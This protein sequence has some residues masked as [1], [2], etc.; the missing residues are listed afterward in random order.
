MLELAE[1]ENNVTYASVIESGLGS[2]LCIGCEVFGRWSGQCVEL[3][4]ELACERT[5]GVHPRLRRGMAL[6]LQHRWWGV[7]GIALQKSVAEMV[8]NAGAGADLATGRLEPTPALSDLEL[9]D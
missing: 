8:M 4:P 6:S 5:R 3:V 1:E 9:A 7:L 2:L